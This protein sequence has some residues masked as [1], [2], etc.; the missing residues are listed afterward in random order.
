MPLTSEALEVVRDADMLYAP[1]KATNAGG[2][3]ISGLEMTQN[4]MGV[5]WSRDRVSSELQ[6]IMREIHDKCMQASSE[7]DLGTD[8]LAGANIAGFK[9]VAQSMI[10][11]GVV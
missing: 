5:Y 8:Y 11:Q 1:G 9:K 2:V 6:E 7:Y 10:S 4:K 3:A